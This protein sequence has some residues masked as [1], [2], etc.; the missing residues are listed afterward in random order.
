MKKFT[1]TILLLLFIIVLVLRNEVRKEQEYLEKEIE[2]TRTQIEALAQEQYLIQHR[3]HELDYLADIGLKTLE[4][5]QM[6]EALFHAT[7]NLETGYGTSYMWLVDNN[8]GGI[9]GIRPDGSYGFMRYASKEK[10]LKALRLKLEEYVDM[11]GYDLQAIRY[12]YCYRCGT[13]DL[14]RFT[15]IFNEEL[16]KIKEEK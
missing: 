13:E 6:F 5:E 1:Y 3:V 15:R 12:R 8:A 9:K 16:Q 11:F 14:E 2:L 7:F 4:E 10:G